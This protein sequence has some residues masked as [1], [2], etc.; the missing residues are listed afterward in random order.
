[1]IV[2]QKAFFQDLTKASTLFLL[3][4]SGLSFAAPPHISL[5]TEHL[6]P[7]QIITKDN[8]ITGVS[9]DIIKEV[10]HRSRL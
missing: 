6:P 1:M 3:L 4:A 2:I 8:Q 5:V 7:Y 9:T 10:M